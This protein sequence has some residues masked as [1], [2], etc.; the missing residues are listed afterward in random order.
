[1]KWLYGGICCVL[2]AGSATQAAELSKTSDGYTYFNLVGATQDQHDSD[3]RDCRIKAGQMHQPARQAPVVVGGGLAGVLGA[4]IGEA[5]VMQM[6]E[7]G[8]RPV[9]IENC[10]VAKGWRVVSLDAKTGEEIAGLNSS[11]K[12][13]RMTPMIGEAVPAGT[14]VRTFDN[15][16]TRAKSSAM[17]LPGR[18]TVKAMLSMDAMR[19]APPPPKRQAPELPEMAKTARPPSPLK[20]EDLGEIPKDSGL[21]VVNLQNSESLSLVFERVGKDIDSPAWLDGH[22][23]QFTV[24]WPRKLITTAGAAPG[25]TQVF[26]LPAGRWRLQ[27]IVG[28]GYQVSFCLGAPAF[29]LAVGDVVF[30]GAFDPKAAGDRLGPDLQVDA[31][32][33]VFP[34]L[35]GL[36]DRMKPAIYTNGSIGTCQGA[37]LYAFEVAGRP[38][39]TGYAFGSA[40][41]VAANMAQPAAPS[42]PAAASPVQTTPTNS[43]EKPTR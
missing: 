4:A 41:S 40:R 39:E 25:S 7:S 17:F 10:M 29:D 28:G 13:A 32:R 31:Y 30:A 20:P 42:T 16:A 26:A 37:Y 2:V 34:A 27:S 33:S 14:V 12:T 15:D 11:A 38:F 21:V 19:D 23:G 36:G 18:K 35:S 8:S 22:P 1:M 3:L 43:A 6:Q 9:N 5:I 24:S